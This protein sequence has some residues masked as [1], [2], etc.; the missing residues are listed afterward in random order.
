M[1]ACV[2]WSQ[3]R[4]AEAVGRDCRRLVPHP[5]PYDHDHVPS[6]R[7]SHPRPDLCCDGRAYRCPDSGA[8]GGTVTVLRLDC[9]PSVMIVCMRHATLLPTAAPTEEPTS[10][11]TLSPTGTPVSAAATQWSLRLTLLEA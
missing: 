11:P 1:L 10:S 6:L 3:R 9:P 8:Y 2:S 7:C 4:F 5:R